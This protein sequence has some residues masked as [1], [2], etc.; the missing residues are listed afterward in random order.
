MKEFDPK[1]WKA[2]NVYY[3]YNNHKGLK[4]QLAVIKIEKV[5]RSAIYYTIIEGEHSMQAYYTDKGVRWDVIDEC[6]ANSNVHAGITEFEF[7]EL[8]LEELA[9]FI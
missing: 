8:S 1:T 7:F 2:E 3:I 9:N 5:T 6:E 4:K